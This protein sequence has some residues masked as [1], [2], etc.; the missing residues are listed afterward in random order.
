[1]GILE[2]HPSPSFREAPLKV[3]CKSNLLTRV[4]GRD[5][6][7][8]SEIVARRFEFSTFFINPLQEIY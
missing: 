7:D 1:M 8:R 5:G 6:T 4:N 2:L 3:F